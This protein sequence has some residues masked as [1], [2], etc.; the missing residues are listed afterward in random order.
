MQPQDQT[1]TNP[2]VTSFSSP[3]KRRQIT[4]PNLWQ[5][6]TLVLVVII[7]IMVFVWR[8]WQP[9]IKAS[10][11]TVSV[12]GD[13]TVSATPDQYQFTPSYDFTNA[14]K[15][16][17]LNSLTTKSN[18]IVSHLKSLGVADKD[19]KTDSGGYGSDGYFPSSAANGKTTYTLSLT[20]TVD[21]AKLAQKVQDYL[22]T[23]SPTG[24]VTPYAS[25][26]TAKEK[27]LQA[28][29][30]SKA[31]QDAKAKADQSAKNLGF[32]VDRVKSVTDGSLG[33]VNPY[34]PVFAGANSANDAQASHLNL[35]PGQNDLSYSVQV[36]YYIH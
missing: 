29:A 12:T 11:R 23:T 21:D 25:F 20:V 2:P 35:Q 18:D 27:Q 36:V 34:G 30:R 15:Q 7:A 3:P 33:G 8:P 24:E 19:I 4:L 14:D 1:P 22:L 13:A 28:Q 32:K 6:V 17:A 9:N 31:E 10:A 26:S 16:A 5:L